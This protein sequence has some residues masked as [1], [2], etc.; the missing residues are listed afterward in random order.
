MTGLN[1]RTTSLLTALA[2]FLLLLPAAKDQGCGGDDVVIGDD[3]EG[4]S[5]GDDGTGAG[6][7]SVQCYVGGCSG[8]LCT[9]D[10]DAA[11]TCEWLPEYACYQQHGICE[12]DAADNCGWKDTP[13]LQ[14]CLGALDREPVEGGCARDND[15]ACTSDADCV[16][17][18][19][20]GELC[21]NPAISE[22]ITTCDCTTP[23]VTGCGCVNGTCSWYNEP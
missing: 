10:P 19:C 7:S 11:S 4:G 5:G 15:D 2:A 6:N 9:T 1:K 21:H 3:G 12:A 13:E 14:Q 22:G 17:G 20:G 18:G 23:S 16:A 8:Q